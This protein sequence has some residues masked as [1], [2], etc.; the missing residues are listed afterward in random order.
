MS[1]LATREDL[2]E[3]PGLYY[4]DYCPLGVADPGTPSTHTARTEESVYLIGT[5]PS[6]GG[7]FFKPACQFNTTVIGSDSVAPT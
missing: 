1:G 4:P 2:R 7:H 6:A 5:E 3:K